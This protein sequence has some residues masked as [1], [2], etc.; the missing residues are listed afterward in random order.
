MAIT[1]SLHG[2]LASLLRRPWRNQELLQLPKERA[3]SVKDV[4]ESFGL[5]HT[6]VG[7]LRVDSHEVDFDY[8]ISTSCHIDI[9]PVRAPWDVLQPCLLR[10]HPLSHLHFLV[11]INVGKLGRLLRMAGFDAASHADWDDK[12]L[13]A[14]AEAEGHLVLSKNRA[15]LMRNKIH[16]GRLIRATAPTE[17]LHEVIN[18]LN[19][20]DQMRPLSRCLECN[21]L[22]ERVAKEEIDHLLEPLTRK[23]YRQFSRCPICAKL[24]WPG[25]H[26]E[27][28][29]KLLPN[30]KLSR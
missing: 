9:W 2:D 6:E 18:L 14:C 30:D 1:L 26:V 22:L 17:Q 10:P 28:M 21:T 23:Y 24:Y 5:P 4:V 11:D 27:K 29:L 8:L 19:L 16:F 7:C 3:A 13:A 25:S 20:H 15:L 12:E